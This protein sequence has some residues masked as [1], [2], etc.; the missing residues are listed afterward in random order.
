MG[1]NKRQNASHEARRKA[2]LER[3]AAEIAKEEQLENTRI[4]A[5]KALLALGV[6]ASLGLLWLFMQEA[7][8]N[9]DKIS[10]SLSS[11]SDEIQNKLSNGLEMVSSGANEALNTVTHPF[12]TMYEKI[13]NALWYVGK[14]AEYTFYAG[15]AKASMP[16]IKFM[17]QMHK[18]ALEY[19][20]G[21]TFIRNNYSN[22]A[23]LV[24]SF[25]TLATV[26]AAANSYTGFAFGAGALA[27]VTAVTSTPMTRSFTY[28]ALKFVGTKMLSGIKSL[29]SSRKS[30]S[31]IEALPEQDMPVLRATVVPPPSDFAD[32]PR[33]TVVPPPSYLDD[34][35]PLAT[36]LNFSTAQQ[37]GGRPLYTDKE[38]SDAC[39]N[40]TGLSF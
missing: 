11:V 33:A 2:Y 34:D 31:S 6:V 5:K 7:N 28:A 29:M 32:F 24:S 3:R 12:V 21:L 38:I 8:K 4:Y 39:A 30:N 36:V 14:G 10:E 13:A 16:V 9:S 19:R 37:E 1:K 18:N 22:I 40:R 26:E 27:T 25:S 20:Y 23:L 35:V 15:L 17:Y